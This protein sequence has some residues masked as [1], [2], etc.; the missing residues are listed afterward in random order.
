MSQIFSSEVEVAQMANGQAMTVPVYSIKGQGNGPSVYIQA[1]IHGAEVQGNA[2]IYQLLEQLKQLDC[3]GDITLVPLANPIGSNQKSGEFTLGRFDPITGANWN[4]GYHFNSQLPQQFAKDNPELP[5]IEIVK[6]YRALIIA[7]LEQQR[8]DAPYGVT[9]GQLLC[10]KLQRMAFE[11]DIVLDL[12]T[13]PISSRHLYCPEYT[14]DSALLFDIPHVLF[15]PCDF[16]GALDEACFCPWWQ[17]QQ[18]Y[19]EQGREI[20]VA[21][22]AFTLEL[23]SQEWL[24]LDEAKRDSQSILSYLSHHGVVKQGSFEPAQMTRYGCYLKDY[25]T[26]Y[27]PKSGLVEYLAPLGREI[28]VGEPLVRMLRIDRYGQSQGDVVEVTQARENCIPILHFASASVNQ[29]TELYKLFTNYFT[30]SR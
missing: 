3:Y 11:A 2:V 30:L 10:A 21:V 8:F 7:D 27:A 19:G 20:A 17:L 29:G 5:M 28:R 9:T 25:R 1:N 24:C 26:V 18:A 15:I 4:R 12:H 16:D 23:G 6:Q 14:K 13:G 22:N